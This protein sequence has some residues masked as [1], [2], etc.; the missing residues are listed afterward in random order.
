MIIC[1]SVEGA[2][3]GVVVATMPYRTLSEYDAIRIATA[4]QNEGSHSR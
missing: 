1:V 3:G 4:V 2:G